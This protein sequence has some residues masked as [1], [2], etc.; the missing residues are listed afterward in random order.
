MITF[1]NLQLIKEMIL[2][3]VVWWTIVVDLIK[4]QT[5][6]SDPKAIK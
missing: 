6:Q 2:E 3:L 1:E 5:L 4:Q